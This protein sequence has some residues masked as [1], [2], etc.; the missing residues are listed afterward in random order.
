LDSDRRDDLDDHR[1]RLFVLSIPGIALA[2]PSHRLR[3]AALRRWANQSEVRDGGLM[4]TASGDANR[5]PAKANFVL[6]GV[7]VTLH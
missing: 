4:M 1:Q 7:A 5:L 3:A 2:A 6:R